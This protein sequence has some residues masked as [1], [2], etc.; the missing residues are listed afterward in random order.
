MSGRTSNN[1][2]RLYNRGAS[3]EATAA[4]VN[5]AVQDVINEERDLE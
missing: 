2:L 1:Q 5:E 4:R 3:N